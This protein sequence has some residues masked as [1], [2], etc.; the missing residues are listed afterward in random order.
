MKQPGDPRAQY[1]LY[2]FPYAGGGSSV[3]RS[4]QAEFGPSVRVKPLLWPGREARIAEPA[5]A[6]VAALARMASLEIERD[7]GRPFAL[8]GYS[9]GSLVAFE[10]ARLL[11]G[12]GLTPSALIVAAL[13]PPHI[14]HGGRR[15]HALPPRELAAELRKLKGTPEA[16]LRDP[17]LMSL[18]LPAIRADFEAYETYRYDEQEPLACPISAL[19]GIA[20]PSVSQ[21]DL[22][23]WSQHTTGR[24]RMRM[25]PGDHFFL[26]TARGLV[27]WAILQDLLTPLR[28]AC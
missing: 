18:V 3:F 19:G 13:R 4:W 5:L 7:R 9:F 23:A 26:Q 16:V 20:D 17:E 22:V 27:V 6:S 2:C 24:F 1:D 15:I 14:P 28:A 11:R 10:T 25:L 8:F 12:R 21:A